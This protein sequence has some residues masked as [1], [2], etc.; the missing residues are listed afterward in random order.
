MRHERFVRHGRMHRCSVATDRR[1][2]AQHRLRPLVIAIIAA[3]AMSVSGVLAHN[4]PDHAAKTLPPGN[5]LI[6]GNVAQKLRPSVTDLAAM[7]NQKTVEVTFRAGGATE[8]RIFTG[9]LLLDVLARAAPQFDPAIKND[10]LRHFRLGD[11][12]V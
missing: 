1:I 4:R 9:P 5:F 12:G 11:G 8:H 10:K 3:M 7:P 2:R 6:T